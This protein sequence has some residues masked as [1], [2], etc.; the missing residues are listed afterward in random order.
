MSNPQQ[1]GLCCP[2]RAQNARLSVFRSYTA[3]LHTSRG[4]QLNA[5]LTMPCLLLSTRHYLQHHLCKSFELCKVILSVSSCWICAIE[6]AMKLGCFSPVKS[7]SPVPLY[8]S[9]VSRRIVAAPARLPLTIC[10][11]HTSNHIGSFEERQVF[12][13]QEVLQHGGNLDGTYIVRD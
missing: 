3:N 4:E 2:T 13:G 10:N 5:P 1:V 9:S 8:C 7:G 6:L 11:V 12:N